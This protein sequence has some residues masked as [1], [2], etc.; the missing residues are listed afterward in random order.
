MN[1]NRYTI[2]QFLKSDPIYYK[3][4]FSYLLMAGF[5]FILY[6]FLVSTG[7]KIDPFVESKESLKNIYYLAGGVFI[8]TF[9][10]LTIFKFFKGSTKGLDLIITFIGF[11]TLFSILNITFIG[12]VLSILVCTVKYYATQNKLIKNFS[13]ILV[14]STFATLIGYSISFLPL[15]IFA[16]I[17]GI[18]DYIAVYKTKHMVYMAKNIKE[19]N[20][21]FTIA[22][23]YN[24]KALDIGSGDFA[25]PLT[26]V[27]SALFV[28]LYLAIAILVLSI[29]MLCVTI[30][31]LLNKKEGEKV[32]PAL[33]LQVISSLIVYILFL[34]IF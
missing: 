21:I 31:L 15:L 28:N 6:Y 4:I 18:Y 22:L 3:I 32:I 30:F 5:S 25:I 2:S 26:L 14:T 23:L 33:P 11:E 20:Y 19:T 13:M 16:L 27:I 12:F 34:A 7:V 29:I 1:Q 10:M 24:K 17:L 8:S 9:L